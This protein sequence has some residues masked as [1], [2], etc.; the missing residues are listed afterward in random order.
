MCIYTYIFFPQQ[1]FFISISSISSFN[2]A[3]PGFPSQEPLK[4]LSENRLRT[5]ARRHPFPPAAAVW[6]HLLGLAGL[7]ALNPLVTSLAA[8]GQGFPGGAEV[9]LR[10]AP[11]ALPFPQAPNTSISAS[12][13]AGSA[14]VQ[15]VPGNP[16]S[17]WPKEC[18][19]GLLTYRVR[20]VGGKKGP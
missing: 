20:R 17:S 7:P 5:P 12:S 11:G 8:P 3:I 6:G 13:V 18:F 10:P 4:A 2:C 19:G 14:L 15:G 1:D 9:L 16:R